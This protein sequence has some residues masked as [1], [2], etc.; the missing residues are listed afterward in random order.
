MKQSKRTK[1]L[2]FLFLVMF[3]FIEFV[4]M[5]QIEAISAYASYFFEVLWVCGVLFAF[6]GFHWFTKGKVLQWGA[7]VFLTG[8][9]GA[10]VQILAFRRGI[11]IPLDLE[12]RE[13][14]LLLLLIGPVLEEFIF[15]LGLWKVSEFF[16]KNKWF[17]ILF[18]SAIF[19]YCH[20][21]MIDELPASVRGFIIYQAAYTFVLGLICGYLRSGYGMLAALPA[22]LLFNLGFWLAR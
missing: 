4:F 3:L 6:K 18:T 17:L 8:V 2:A 15:R 13:T 16:V 21:W 5:K 10:W 14:I 9:L 1:I 11:P 19:S 12:N 20:Y 7:I 22:H